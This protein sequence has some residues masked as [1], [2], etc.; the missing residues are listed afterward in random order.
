[1]SSDPV[2]P[3]VEILDIEQCWKL[4]SGAQVG[5][6]AVTV[7]GRP[8][9][10]PVNYKVDEKTLLFR[11]GEGTKLSAINNDAWVAFEADMVEQGT[12]VA[13]SVVVKGTIRAVP[14]KGPALNSTERF[15][16]PWQGVGRSHLVRISPESVTGR[17]FLLEASMTWQT[18]LNGSIR[19]GLE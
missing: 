3:E 5:R 2:V 9:I 16:F 7:D 6:L 8:D 1:M 11:T 18:S 15:L 4:L 12:G 19:A 13:W 17:R 10:F 14:S